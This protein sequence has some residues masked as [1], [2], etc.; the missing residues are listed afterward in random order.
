MQHTAIVLAIVGAAAGASAQPFAHHIAEPPSARESS[1]D[2]TP[3]IGERLASVGGISAEPSSFDPRGYLVVAS[4]AGVPLIS[5]II[6][7][8]DSTHNELIA[9]R[10]DPADERL[11]VLQDALVSQNPPTSDLTLFKIDPATGAF[12]YQIRYPG[13]AFGENLGMEL[14]DATGLVAA[15]VTNTAGNSQCTLL[16]FV[17]ATGLPMFHV[18][19]QPVNAPVSRMRFYDVTRGPGGLFAVGSV[20]VGVTG[21]APERRVLV[22]HFTP[23]GIPVWFRAYR[24][25]LQNSN[26][27]GPGEGVSIEPTPGGRVGVVARVQDPVFGAVAVHMTLDPATGN[28]V[29]F[30]AL[31]NTAGAIRP[32]TSSL[33]RTPDGLMLVSGAGDNTAGASVPA[34]W[35]FDPATGALAWAWLPDAASGVGNSAVPQPGRGPLVSGAVVPVGGAF[36]GLVDLFLARTTPAGDGLC[37]KTPDFRAINVDPSV[38][39][40]AVETIPMP[41]PEP[42]DLESVRGDPRV[43]AVCVRCPAD[44]ASPFGTLD[45]FDLAAFI[46]LYNNSDPAADLAAPFGVF[47]FFDVAAYLDLFNAGCP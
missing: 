44:L 31:S 33:E 25:V 11:I 21:G 7:D 18:R 22:A 27:P 6:R 10:Q 4:P 9:T 46:T 41:V 2:L 20:E 14:D 45:F 29:V 35:A 8:P 37:D 19:Y 36:G 13:D 34:M 42:A 30:A 23:A 38:L 26:Q 15:G 43:G 24:L 3:L 1:N 32:A 47:N 40:I 12:G 28:P 39:D 16:R 5:W 17:N